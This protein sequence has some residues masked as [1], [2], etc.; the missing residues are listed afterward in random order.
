MARVAFFTFGV[1]R[2]PIGHPQTKGF[3]DRAPG[4]FAEA[5]A[6]PGF[7]GYPQEMVAR[8]DNPRLVWPA[9]KGPDRDAMMTLSLWK[10]LESVFAFSYAR[11]GIHADALRLRKQ[12][13]L[14]PEWPNY[15]GWWAA[16]DHQ[17]TWQEAIDRHHLLSVRGPTADAF[18]FHSP[19]DA[20]GRPIN[21]LRRPIALDVAPRG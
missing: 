21:A 1:L 5:S 20:A 11:Q 2:E 12:W 4:A 16:D 15:V 17:P 7:I 10:D 3:E 19:F 13:F 8:P 6:A 14:K 18:D 9:A